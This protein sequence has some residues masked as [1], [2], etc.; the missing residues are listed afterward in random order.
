MELNGLGWNGMKWNEMDWD[1]MEWNGMKGIKKN[2]QTQ[3]RLW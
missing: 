2:K 1:G 3:S